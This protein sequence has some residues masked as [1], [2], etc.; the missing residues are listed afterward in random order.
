MAG[1]GG[2]EYAFARFFTLEPIVHARL[3]EYNWP[4]T[5]EPD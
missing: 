5:L 1:G 3:L 4:N 2:V